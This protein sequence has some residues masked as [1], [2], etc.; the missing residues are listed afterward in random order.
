MKFLVTNFDKQDKMQVLVKLKN[1]VHGEFFK[2]S[3][4]AASYPAYH[5]SVIRKKFHR[6]VFEI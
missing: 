6:T 1:S 5:N 4:K 2:T 3:P